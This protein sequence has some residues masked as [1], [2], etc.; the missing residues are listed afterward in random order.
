MK[1]FSHLLL[2]VCL[3][4]CVPAVQAQTQAN[5]NDTACREYKQSDAELNRVYRQIQS[6]YR[7]DKIFLKKLQLAQRA[8]LAYRDAQLTALFPSEEPGTY[9]SVYPICRCVELN[10][11]TNKRTEEWK[12]WLAGTSEGDVCAGSLKLKR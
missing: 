8:W 5:L 12:R 1:Q 2:L 6:E 9:G 11:L 7:T 4:V 10:E 3:C